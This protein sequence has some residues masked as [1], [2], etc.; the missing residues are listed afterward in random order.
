MNTMD[1]GFAPMMGE[2]LVHFAG[3]YETDVYRTADRRYVVKLK[4]GRSLQRREALEEARAMRAVAERFTAF[5]GAK[6]TIPSTYVVARSGDA[7]HVLV[8][9]PFLE[10]AR[11]LHALDAGE[12]APV[13][14]DALAAELREVVRRAWTCYRATGLLPDLYG[15]GSATA[16]ERRRHRVWYLAPLY[17]WTFFVTR[18]LLR[19]HNLLLTEAPERRVVLVDYDIALADRHHLVR[20]A[21]SAVRILLFVRDLL[22]LRRRGNRPALRRSRKP[23][24][25]TDSLVSEKN[26]SRERH[27]TPPL[28]SSRLPAAR[29]LP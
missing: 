9:Q 12:L 24:L 5:L 17:V 14:A 2:A 22:L 10:H 16:D 3:G 26:R 29:V 18:T 8:V 6:R 25:V 19:S 4:P 23:R 7:V 28:H 11:P 21:Y 20:R 15:L 1:H 27:S 13:E